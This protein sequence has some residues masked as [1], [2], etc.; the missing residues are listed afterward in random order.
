MN[1]IFVIQLMVS[2]I[3]GG[4]FVT[5]LTLLAEKSSNRIS[6][7]ILSFPSTVLIS[8]FFLAWTQSTEDVATIIPATLIPI[9]VSVLFPVFYIYF[10]KLGSEFINGRNQLILFSLISATLIWLVL[11]IPM[12]YHKMTNMLFGIIGYIL[13]AII[14]HILLNRKKSTKV[15]AHSYTIWQIVARAVF[16]GLLVSV[17]VFLGEISNPFWGGVLAIYPAALSASLIVIHWHYG[18]ENLFELCRKIPLG[19]LSIFVYVIVVMIV[20]PIYGFVLGTA[21]ALISSLLTS[22]FLS[23]ISKFSKKD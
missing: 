12:A 16:V 20:F 22:L 8:F 7:I 3:V 15:Q 2:F 10:A 9:G 14:G 18:H 17:V 5:L 19:S 13:L 21:I 23:F 11:S 6:G 1:S 4:G